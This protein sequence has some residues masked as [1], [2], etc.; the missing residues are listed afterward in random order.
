MERLCYT[1][2]RGMGGLE[3]V[4]AQGP[5]AEADGPVQIAELVALASNILTHQEDQE[6]FLHEPAR[7]EALQTIL[8]VEPRRWRRA[9]A[10]IAWNPGAGEVRSGHLDAPPGFGH[11]LL[12]FDG[13]SGNKD[14]ERRTPRAME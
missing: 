2:R 10:L 7:D 6:T 13:V 5:S 3:F 1:G 9:K 14:E 11:W 12:K 4:P 8:R